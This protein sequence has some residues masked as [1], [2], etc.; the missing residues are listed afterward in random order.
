MRDDISYGFIALI[1]K[2]NDWHVLLVK[3]STDYWGFVKGHAEAGE[4]PLETA[5]RELFEETGLKV[6]RLLYE[7]TLTD[8]YQFSWQGEA[9]NKTVVYYLAEVHGEL[10]LQANEIV[11]AKWVPLSI[12]AEQVTFPQSQV[13]CQQAQ[14]LLQS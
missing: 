13:L 10:N 4:S 1:K 8:N 3:H 5:H 2:S 6:S 12:A 9:I 14:V 11:D 7:G